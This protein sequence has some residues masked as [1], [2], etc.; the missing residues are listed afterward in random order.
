[1]ELKFKS[2]ARSYAWHPS[3]PLTPLG[4]RLASAPLFPWVPHSVHPS[5]CAP[6]FFL[7]HKWLNVVFQIKLKLFFLAFKSY[8]YLV[9][10][11][12]ACLTS[13]RHIQHSANCAQVGL[14]PVTS[15]PAINKAMLEKYLLMN[16]ESTEC[17]SVP[18]GQCFLSSLFFSI[19]EP[20]DSLKASHFPQQLL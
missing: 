19:S 12:F 2:L 13:C 7:K 3:Q 17:K 14:Y 8:H 11:Y 5:H 15:C 16:E 20:R 6:L 10:K 18:W 4:E 1:M 9:P